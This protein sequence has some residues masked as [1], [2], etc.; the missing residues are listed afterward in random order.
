MQLRT[1][2][3]AISESETAATVSCTPNLTPHDRNK[4]M[5]LVTIGPF[6]VELNPGETL[7]SKLSVGATYG[8]EKKGPLVLDPQ[9]VK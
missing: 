5:V 6:A 9:P 1:K 4:R 3:D 7:A 8:F 2:I